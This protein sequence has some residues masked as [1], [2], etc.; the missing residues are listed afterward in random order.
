MPKYS[1]VTFSAQ[2]V[3]S[4]GK[5]SGFVVSGFLSKKQLLA[6]RSLVDSADYQRST[7]WR[8]EYQEMAKVI[9]GAV[10]EALAK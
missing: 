6:L 8:G 1:A 2:P 3:E 10:D 5:T 7:K 4:G 9:V